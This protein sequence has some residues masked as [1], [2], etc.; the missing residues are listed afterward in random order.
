[1]K[2]WWA[3][4]SRDGTS[5]ALPTPFREAPTGVGTFLE[6]RPVKATWAEFAS[7]GQDVG[8]PSSFRA[9]ALAAVAPPADDE[10]GDHV[11]F[12]IHRVVVR[13][14]AGSEIVGGES[15]GGE[16]GRAVSE[17]VATEPCVAAAAAAESCVQ[18]SPE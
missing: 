3:S 6:G 17:T 9:D 14:V 4:W 10:I 1:M 16:R 7:G 5:D 15:V 18:K 2:E 12:R 11:D 8:K 13:P